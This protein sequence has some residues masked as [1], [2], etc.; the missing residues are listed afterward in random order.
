MKKYVCEK[1]RKPVALKDSFCGHCGSKLLTDEKVGLVK[2]I[3][4]IKAALV[5]VGFYDDGDR[6]TKDA[7]DARSPVYWSYWPDT[8]PEAVVAELIAGH[9]MNPSN[10]ACSVSLETIESA[11][12]VLEWEERGGDDLNDSQHKPSID[13]EASQEELDV[14]EEIRKAAP[15]RVGLSLVPQ[16]RENHDLVVY[17]IDPEMQM[18]FSEYGGKARYMEYYGIPKEYGTVLV[19]LLARTFFVAYCENV[20]TERK[21]VKFFEKLG[22]IEE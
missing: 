16:F 10:S 11:A 20:S 4:T 21:V 22:F 18:D 19:N 15:E 5:E 6:F 14:I 2:E 12:I 9:T 8:L 1:C 7:E 3:D 13:F 17:T